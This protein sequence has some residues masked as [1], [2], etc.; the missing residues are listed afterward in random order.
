MAG[1]PLRAGFPYASRVGLDDLGERICIIGQ[2]GS[3]K[4]TLADAIGRS[5]RLPVHHLDQYRHLPEAGWKP[6]PDAEFERL[7]GDAI[8][9]EK[10]VIDGNYS[11]LLP[12]RLQRATGL[13]LLDIPTSLA[14][15]RNV[16]RTVSDARLG[17]LGRAESLS[18]A[19][20]RFIATQSAAS[21]VRRRRLFDDLEMPKIALSGARAIDRF[22]AA[23]GL[24]RAQ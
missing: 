13:I 5:R 24:R 3:G 10:W 8:A 7:H 1:G 6:R 9:G 16:R 12:A 22:Y 15:V 14:L 19:R 4:S 21:R 11:I 17:G 20:L 2:S 18:W 23:D